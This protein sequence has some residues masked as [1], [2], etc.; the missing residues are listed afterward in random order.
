MQSEAST[1]KSAFFRTPLLGALITL[2]VVGCQESAGPPSASTPEPDTSLRVESS[3]PIV[4]F[5]WRGT[6]SVLADTNGAAL[7]DIV[8]LP[9][10]QGLLVQTLDKLAHAPW[11]SGG[12]EVE[13]RTASLLRPLLG[14]ILQNET[15][16]EVFRGDKGDITAAL[17]VRL[18]PEESAQWRTNVF[19]IAQTYF[20]IRTPVSRP[21]DVHWVLASDTPELSTPLTLSFS[22]EGEWTLVVLAKDGSEAVPP[23]LSAGGAQ[24]RPENTYWLRIRADLAALPASLS[25]STNIFSPLPFVDVTFRG[26]NHKVQTEAIIH[27]SEELV[28]DLGQWHVP[29]D[30]IDR[31]SS[32]FFAFRGLNHLL[33][34]A[35]VWKMA[36]FSEIPNQLFGWSF[37][38]HPA[39]TFYAM[40]VSDAAR[41]LAQVTHLLLPDGH[42]WKTKD[43]MAGFRRAAEHDGIEWQGLPYLWPFVR[44]AP[45]KEGVY[46]LGGT[47]AY[48]F[49]LEPLPTEFF[50]SALSADDLVFYGW[51]RTGIRLE[52]WLYITQFMRF[53]SGVDQLP[54]DS[55]AVSWIKA[56]G[57]KLGE[58]VTRV[59]V[60]NSRTIK[61]VRT[62]SLGF[63]ASELHLLVDWLE[64]PNFPLGLYSFSPQ[65]KRAASQ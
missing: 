33:S 61:L 55:A 65:G 16:L 18:P 9:Q 53:V 57:S 1:M 22:Q 59:Q 6:R 62:S 44:S 4:S 54:F 50:E 23:S 46:V 52:Q 7:Q 49:P 43:E 63:T 41:F 32:S 40:R 30:L 60:V 3:Q 24:V 56:L 8:S 58:S 35:N 2:T 13:P 25:I 17:A 34:K 36:G 14:H 5:H 20:G 28:L 11:V 37:E 27:F 48:S 31:P 47:F 29:A 21:G 12:K 19:T 10:T 38:E 26:E 45:T 42:G 51:E 15:R 64:S 39:F